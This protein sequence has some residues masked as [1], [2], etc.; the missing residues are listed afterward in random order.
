MV[1]VVWSLHIVI[2]RVQSVRKVEALLQSESSCPG[3]PK[4][5]S[6]DPIKQAERTEHARALYELWKARDQRDVTAEVAPFLQD[7]NQNLR[8]SAMRILARLNTPAAETALIN[9]F[10]VMEDDDISSDVFP[11]S[12][13]MTLKRAQTRN[14]KGWAKVNAVAGSAG[15]SFNEVVLLSEKINDK[16]KSRRSG[17]Q[18]YIVMCEIIDLLD[19]MARKGEN[20]EPFANQLTLNSAQKVKLQGVALPRDQELKLIIDHVLSQNK[21]GIN[22]E[23]L[24]TNYLL[25]LGQPATEAILTSLQAVQQQQKNFKSAGLVTLMRAAAL[26]E[27]SRSL[28]LLKSFENNPDPKIRYYAMQ[29]R[30]AIERQLWYPPLP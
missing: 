25:S 3:V 17:T 1:S 29:S 23:E 19:S 4:P 15:L 24:G 11:I 10:G 9:S 26:T 16:A 20:I 28:S 12:W 7:G 8:E 27:D 21:V 30:E 13:R 6:Y 18:G 22:E 2:Q 5:P 14:L